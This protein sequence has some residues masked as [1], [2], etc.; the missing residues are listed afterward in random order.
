[1]WNVSVILV[2]HWLAVSQS[3]FSVRPDDD[4]TNESSGATDCHVPDTSSA[5]DDFGQHLAGHLLLAASVTPAGTVT[6]RAEDR[7]V[8]TS[9]VNAV[10]WTNGFSSVEIAG[11]VERRTRRRQGAWLSAVFGPGRPLLFAR[12]AGFLTLRNAGNPWPARPEKVPAF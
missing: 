4:R 2:N 1:M 5:R 6:A 8:R 11:K 7:N 9:A 3:T 12:H 10:A